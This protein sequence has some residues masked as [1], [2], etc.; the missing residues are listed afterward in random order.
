M[1]SLIDQIRAFLQ[2]HMSRTYI[3]DPT[4]VVYVRKG[5]RIINNDLVATLDI[6]SVNAYPPGRGIFTQ[7]ITQLECELPTF[8]TI[9]CIFIESIVNDAFFEYLMRR[10]YMLREPNDAY[11]IVQNQEHPRTTT[12]G[13]L[14]SPYEEYPEGMRSPR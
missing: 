6:A 13:Q 5:R 8:S 11:K 10:G 4:L 1:I 3:S 2:S 9:M 7:F 12:Q 14:K